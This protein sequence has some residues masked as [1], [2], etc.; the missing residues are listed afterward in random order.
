VADAAQGL[1]EIAL[2]VSADSDLCPAIRTAR[3]IAAETR[4]KRLGM[5]LAFPPR[6]HSWDLKALVPRAF[7]LAQA[8]LRNSLLPPVVTDRATGNAYRRPPSWH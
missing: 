1:A 3:G 4:G 7:T 6:R 5:V 2:L 8:D